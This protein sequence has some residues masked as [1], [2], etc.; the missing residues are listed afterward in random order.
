M[1]KGGPN[2]ILPTSHS[3]VT[4]EKKIWPQKIR[5][6]DPH[7]GFQI[8][9]VIIFCDASI[10]EHRALYSMFLAPLPK[11]LDP[12]L[13]TMPPS[14]SVPRLGEGGWGLMYGQSIL[15]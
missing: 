3:G 2:E 5:P 15:W 4:A 1:C 6:L 7:L 14:E 12:L 13:I 10:T 8:I 11:F 9:L